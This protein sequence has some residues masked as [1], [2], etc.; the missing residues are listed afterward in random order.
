[1]EVLTPKLN[2][3]NIQSK[4]ILWSVRE[5]FAQS[6]DLEYFWESTVIA[7]FAVNAVIQILQRNIAV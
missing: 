1:M 7:R 4:E 3:Q 2:I 5:N 6:V